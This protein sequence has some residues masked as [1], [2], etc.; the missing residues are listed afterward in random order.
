[1]TAEL[2]ST[3]QTLLRGLESLRDDISR[4]L[5]EVS[6][7]VGRLEER[8]RALENAMRDHERANRTRHDSLELR[9]RNIERELSEYRGAGLRR[10]LALLGLGGTSGGV[11]YALQRWMEK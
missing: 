3:L 10:L 7:G 5:A 9:V 4:R 1:M 6:V 8:Q 11:L 2:E